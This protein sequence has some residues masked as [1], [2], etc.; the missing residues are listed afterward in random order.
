MKS[1]FKKVTASV[2]ALAM[3]LMMF[4]TWLPIR[5]EAD[6][7]AIGTSISVTH[8]RY[9]NGYG[10]AIGFPWVTLGDS[11]MN[12]TFPKLTATVNGSYRP[13]FCADISKVCPNSDSPVSDNFNAADLSYSSS[14]ITKLNN[15]LT[16]VSKKDF[17][18]Y[19]PNKNTYGD[20]S[21]AA[22]DEY[23]YRIAAQIVIWG[24]IY[25]SLDDSGFVEKFFGDA[26]PS[27]VQSKIGTSSSGYFKT[28]KDIA[29]E[30][31]T[32]P[33]K[34]SFS[35][36]KVLNNNNG[37]S[38]T[39][40][41]S[42]GVLSD[43]SIS[44]KDGL[45]VT[46]SGNTLTISSSGFFE[47]TKTVKLESASITSAEAVF[48]N[49]GSGSA[50]LQPCITW[51]RV[52]TPGTE[53]S[54]SVTSE[55][56]TG[57]L[58][59]IKTSDDGNVSG[60][61]FIVTKGSYKKTVTTGTD[62]TI[63]IP[64]LEEGTYTVTETVPTGYEPQE[65]KTVT[66]KAGEIAEVAFV[67][68]LKTGS[69][70]VIK[71]AED[72]L[73]SGIKFRLT[74][75]SDIGIKV[76]EYATTDK[77]GVAEFNDIYIGSNYTLI[78]VDVDAKYV[79]PKAQDGIIIEWNKVTNASETNVQ[80]KFT[81]TVN[82]TDKET[83]SAQGN[84][85]LEGAV[86][87]I[88]NN[89]KLV[90]TYR[91]DKNGS[92]TTKEYV[93]GDNWTIKEITPSEG[94]LLDSTVHKIGADQ[95]L[96]T[97]EHN[98]A[99][100]ITSNEQVKKGRFAVLKTTG[101][102]TGI[103]EL[104][105]EAE[106]DVY[107]KSAGSY[108]KAKDYERDKLVIGGD[109]TATTKDLPYGQYIVHQ[110]KAWEGSQL[111]ADFEVFVDENDF[112]KMIPVNNSRFE[113]RIKVVK[114]DAQTGNAIAY[115]GAGF[116]LYNPDGELITM[117]ITYPDVLIVDT[118]YTNSEGYIITPDVLLGGKGY[119]LQE[120][121][122]PYGYL[123]NSNRIYF[124]VTQSD[125]SIE[126]ETKVT[127]IEVVCEDVPQMGVIEVSKYGEIFASVNN[128]GGVYQPVYETAGLEGAVYKIVAA[129]D[130]Y[131]LDGTLR[132]AEGE[133]VERITTGA[134][135][136]AVSDPL[137]L[138]KYYIIEVTAPYGMIIDD[139]PKT[140][141][142]VYDDQLAEITSTSASFV[143]ERQ[144][145]ALSLMKT[146]EQNELYGLGMNGEVRNVSFG[147]Y[148][149]ADIVA[150]DGT[151]IPEN[152]LIETKFC[153]ENGEIVFTSDL[154]FGTYYAREISTDKHYTL[155]NER[156]E[157]AFDYKGQD[158]DIVRITVNDT[159][160]IN[161]LIYGIVGGIKVITGTNDGL[162]NA[163]IGLFPADT[164]EFTEDNAYRTVVTDEN[165]QF[166]FENIP[167]GEYIVREIKAPTNFLLN[168]NS[169]DVSVTT[170]GE[171]INLT[172]ENTPDYQIGTTATAGGEK[173]TFSAGTIS[174]DDI[175]CYRNLLVGHEYTV[176]GILMDK[177]TGDP[178]LVNGEAV[179]SEA[180]FTA[181]TSDGEVVVTFTFDASGIKENTALVVFEN[182]YEG[183]IALAVH[184]DI[185][186]EDQT[187]TVHNPDIGT[188]V[189]F[190]REKM[191]ETRKIVLDDVIEYHDLIVGKEYIINGV[192]KD[193]NSG[194][195]FQIL[196]E[197]VT[198]EAVFVPETPDG[199]TIVQF[200]FDGRTIPEN[201]NISVVVFEKVYFNGI[202]IAAHED[203]NNADQTIELFP[204]GD[205]DVPK[206]NPSTGIVLNV[207]G[208][209]LATTTLGVV[210][211]N[212]QKKRGSK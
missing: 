152:G 153:N 137:F 147:L 192:L 102:G 58:K 85:T 169:F 184:A 6:A 101:N 72:N 24:I 68:S 199:S 212:R 193:K 187:V 26:M 67:N 135:G 179:K 8:E 183:E 191:E 60:I 162:P 117:Q 45:T 202:E 59:I 114:K 109:G 128:S 188:K 189:A 196:G 182:L 56:S 12:G 170:D 118:F 120:V 105:T 99:P 131:T 132:A 113:S 49:P 91:T 22:N 15:V 81:V 44:E 103:Y 11:T 151:K 55:E 51:E 160:I 30:S 200:V 46:K 207:W 172:I 41:D 201:E 125:T 130:I 168:E 155:N 126:E 88:Y 1:I 205:D 112:Y 69:L 97:V 16:A 185:D 208:T 35:G 38:V 177:N 92:F 171:E 129:E 174:I 47:G 161:S 13:A 98:T 106:F 165:G 139:T 180:I 100:A 25:D 164:L 34:P 96:Y 71:T 57:D 95:K 123:L 94:Y 77:N 80:K 43:Y 66:V 136:I 116:Q 178:F 204:F 203:L 32:T 29:N 146:M 87:G 7:I 140:V 89:D 122:A 78:E 2:T 9:M 79:I 61:E 107:L 210:I 74:G 124:D 104:E 157:V 144:K 108:A 31:S 54:V 197:E 83:G 150:A 181:K 27:V 21:D 134:D 52:T 190:N 5:S 166:V 111:A 65:P 86:Y 209:V 143:N 20:S 4:T 154:P 121:Q 195:N 23:A 10:Y 176:K 167:R 82:K 62:G 75:T 110:T 3:A 175:V 206:G 39:L 33:A 211:V 36:S 18:Y 17:D 63:T 145:L 48:L 159:A 163:T 90:D 149:A 50:N 148:A 40:T 142:L 194:D 28:L 115:A 14:K 76:D 84:G 198:A 64:D 19:Y 138:G 127:I 186:D 93:C 73:V 133:E 156:F 141:E 53:V 158:F 173:E 42:N 119:S 70:K 37:F